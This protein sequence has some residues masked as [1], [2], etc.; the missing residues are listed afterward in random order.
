MSK[1]NQT[2]TFSKNKTSATT[3]TADVNTSLENMG[4]EVLKEVSQAISKQITESK[5]MSTK[6]KIVAL[7]KNRIIF[8]LEIVLFCWIVKQI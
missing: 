4:M 8:L 1:E 3:A 6:E 7:D 2:L 5:D